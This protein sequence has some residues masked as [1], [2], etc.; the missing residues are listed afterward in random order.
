MPKIENIV[1][2][3]R[4]IANGLLVGAF[5]LFL[6][7]MVLYGP[8]GQEEWVGSVWSTLQYSAAIWKG[9]IP[10]MWSDDLGLGTPLPLG[11]RLDLAPPFLLFPIVSIRWVY[12][13]FYAFYLGLGIIY[14]LRLCEDFKFGTFIRLMVGLTFLFSAST[15]QLM[16]VDDWPSLFHDW[17]LFPVLLF[18]L[19][20]LC[21]NSDRGRTLGLIFSLGFVGGLWALN[22]HCGHMAVLASVLAVYAIAMVSQRKDLLLKLIGSA[23]ISILISS[24]H[25]YYLISQ[26]RS[27][28]SY[29]TRF[30]AEDGIS[31]QQ[32]LATLFRPLDTLVWPLLGHYTNADLQGVLSRGWSLYVADYNLRIPFMGT[33]F[34]LVAIFWSLKTF[35][36]SQSTKNDVPDQRALAITILFSFIMMFMKAS[37]FLNIPSGTWLYREGLTLFGL[38]GAGCWFQRKLNDHSRCIKWFPLLFSLHLVQMVIGIYPAIHNTITTPGMR[39]YED[40]G[41]KKGL[42]GWISH[43]TNKE[44]DRLFATNSFSKGFHFV[45]DGLY[46]ITDLTF[47]GVKPFNSY[48]KSVPMDTVA[49]SLC[50]G[51]G[52][53]PGHPDIVT[54]KSMLDVFGINLVLGLESELGDLKLLQNDERSLMLSRFGIQLKNPPDGLELLDERQ[55]LYDGTLKKVLLYRNPAAWPQAFLMDPAITR[56]KEQRACGYTGAICRDFSDWKEY[57]LFDVVDMTG[58]DGRYSIK[59]SPSKR[60]R[61]FVTSKLYRPEWVAIN[62]EGIL[63]PTEQLGGALLGV[64]VLPGERGFTLEF[65]PI[66]RYFLWIISIISLIITV[67]MIL[68]NRRRNFLNNL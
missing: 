14:V 13:L 53:I 11:N 60:E 56:L 43:H 3:R 39:Y 27:F 35:G 10:P 25:M 67:L 58:E 45:D 2:L 12:P 51:H 4:S 40:I 65:R 41:Q 29:I 21:L 63:L 9:H 52:W 62:S 54:N 5:L 46:G 47:L 64:H 19:R 24:E 26:I 33:L 37:W 22:G 7:P 31:L 59:L 48:F 57:R 30:Q 34:I 44:G 36:F 1:E 50:L 23:L 49:Q 8:H 6:L 17:C 18:Y 66:F 16:Y 61:L 28:P 55:S 15:V 32:L 68:F 38:L 20:R 42:P